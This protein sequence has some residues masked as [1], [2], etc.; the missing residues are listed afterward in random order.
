[1]RKVVMGFLCLVVGLC[2]CAALPPQ[3]TTQPPETAFNEVP[4]DT[5]IVLQREACE[6]RCSVY[7]LVIFD[8]GEILW[9]GIAYVQTLGAARR[10]IEPGLIKNWLEEA[11]AMN[12]FSLKS[13]IR[14]PQQD[15]RGEN[16]QASDEMCG[17]KQ[18]DAPLTILSISSG[19]RSNTVLYNRSCKEL[20]NQ[21]LVLLEDK[22][23]AITKSNRWIK[24]VR[25]R[26]NAMINHHNTDLLT[27][28]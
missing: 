26:K 21:K 19:G 5:L 9:D 2:P 7:R 14:V 10:R 15:G 6:G 12:F 3:N 13:G 27:E 8:D 16:S 1:M 17:I 4:P 18:F 24:G 23:V 25:R 11:K 20:T 28:V 22:L